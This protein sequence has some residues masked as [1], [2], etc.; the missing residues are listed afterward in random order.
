[1]PVTATKLPVSTASTALQMAETMFGDGVTILSASYQG[2]PRSAGIYTNGDTVAPGAVP[3]ATGVILSTGIASSF[4]NASGDPN[5]SAATTAQVVG[6]NNDPG[7]NTI[8]GVAT[9]DAAF[10]NASFIPVGDTLT[11]RLVF[12]S[13][14][15]LEWVN[16]GYNDAVGIWVNGVKLS[17]SIGDGNISIDNINTAMNANLFVDNSADIVNTEMDG[18]TRVVTL[19]ADVVPGQPNTIRIGI[20]DAGDRTYDSTL[21]IVAD[22][23]QTALIAVDDSIAITAKGEAVANLLT[24]DMTD[25]RIGVQITHLNDQAVL[26]G[27]SVTLATG[28]VLVLNPDGTVTVQAATAGNAVTFSYTIT[29]ASGTADTAFVTLT[30]SA[31]DGTDGNDQ[32]H[33]GYTDADGNM[34]DGTDGMAEVIM[35]YGGNDKI[36]AGFGDDDIYG[37]TGNDF[38]RAGNG[39]DLIF[40]G[41]GN[42][43]LDGQAGADTMFGGMGDDVYYIDDAGDVISVV[44]GGGYDKVISDISHTLAASFEELWLAEGTSAVT[45]TGNALDNKIVGNANANTLR[46]EAGADQLFGEDGDD[47]LF[48]GSGNDNLFGGAGSDHLYGDDGNDKLFGGVGGNILFGGAGNDTLAAGS[49]GDVLTG[50]TGNDLLSGGAGADVFVFAPG[51][52]RDSIKHFEQSVD[53]LSFDGMGTAGLRVI[54]STAIISFAGGDTITLSGLTDTQNLTLDSLLI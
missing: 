51:F 1:M 6:V 42:D 38:M 12:G 50:G 33:V 9:F 47:F 2:D 48:G 40:G 41:D 3:S 11:M 25:G 24:N 13:E 22:S 10:L 28:D 5:R 17:L 19:K 43:V 14:E 30:P 26:A 31:V 53:F 8:A 46:G 45:G 21:L 49:G 18:I 39:R 52:G 20:A 7:M 29:D 44:G 15:Y 54:G 35:G 34:I 27:Q 4:T 16:S 32:M 36:T 37:G 23:V